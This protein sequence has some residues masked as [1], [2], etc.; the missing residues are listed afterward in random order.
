MTS[1]SLPKVATVQ[2]KFGH[3]SPARSAVGKINSRSVGSDTRSYWP[4]AAWRGFR[5]AETRGGHWWCC[6]S[7]YSKELKLHWLGD[8]QNHREKSNYKEK[9][10]QILMPLLLTLM[11]SMCAKGRGWSRSEEKDSA[12]CFVRTL[13]TCKTLKYIYRAAI[14]C[15][16]K[17][18][19]NVLTEGTINSSTL[20]TGSPN[21]VLATS[22]HIVL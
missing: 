17:R 11:L 18:I 12:H 5:R 13:H 4:H 10:I 14:S 3:R 9:G 16:S 19:T 21:L 8:E 7:F 15:T 2:T 20:W 1:T 22:T 6:F